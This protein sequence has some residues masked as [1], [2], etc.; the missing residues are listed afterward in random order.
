MRFFRS[1]AARK[2]GRPAPTP[3]EF[4]PADE[5]RV[6]AGMANLREALRRFAEEEADQALYGPDPA[7]PRPCG[8][9]HRRP[10]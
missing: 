3:V 9:R 7:P 4:D 6:D 8:A 10:R 1:R 5:A 2:S